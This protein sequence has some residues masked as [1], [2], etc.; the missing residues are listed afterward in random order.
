MS[1]VEVVSALNRRVREGT[2]VESGYPQLRDDFL[3]LCRQ[4]YQLVQATNPVL[5]RA[6]LLLE[7]HALRSYD[8]LQLSSALL[9][10][11]RVMM[12][13]SPAL[14]FLAADARLLAVAAIE[15][16]TVDNPNNYP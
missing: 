16:L 11:D 4:Q 14:T 13:G 6:R 9:T 3:A 10:N 12:L 5:A 8:A 1:T 15:G 7:R 2:V